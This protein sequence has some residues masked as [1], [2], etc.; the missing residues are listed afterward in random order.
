[1]EAPALPGPKRVRVVSRLPF[2][3]TSFLHSSRLRAERSRGVHGARDAVR[4]A[5]RIAA[6]VAMI[7]CETVCAGVADAARPRARAAVGRRGAKTSDIM[8]EP[9]RRLAIQHREGEALHLRVGSLTP[10]AVLVATAR[11]PYGEE[12][13]RR[14]LVQQ[15]FGVACDGRFHA[16]CAQLGPAARVAG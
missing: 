11:M 7:R 6:A 13:A 10:A 16:G 15:P 12:A 5:R 2:A 14:I 4:V 9:A 1:M 8:R 3:Q